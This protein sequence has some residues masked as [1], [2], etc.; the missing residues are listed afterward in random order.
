MSEKDQIDR[1]EGFKKDCQVEGWDSYHG[2][3]ITDIAIENAK[4][5]I[6]S[7]WTSP[8]SDGGISISMMDEAI[9]IELDSEGN[10]EGVYVSIKDLEKQLK[11]E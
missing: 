10:V 9:E 11:K 7:L 2:S 5:I 6:E 1:L 8:K 4:L 3:P